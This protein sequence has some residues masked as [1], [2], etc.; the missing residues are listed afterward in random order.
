M[1]IQLL[2]L[3]HH[4]LTHHFLSA[5]RSSKSCLLLVCF[6]LHVASATSSISSNIQVS[7]KCLLE[8]S[9]LKMSHN[10]ANYLQLESWGCLV[11]PVEVFNC[12]WAE[13]SWVRVVKLFIYGCCCCTP[14]FSIWG[15]V[16][17]PCSSVGAGHSTSM[18]WQFCCVKM[19][20]K[21]MLVSVNTTDIPL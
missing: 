13:W 18:Y 15:L 3:G 10:I 19:A 16:C 20:C 7:S 8:M 14:I 12:V 17:T 9:Y 11:I 4:Y 5:C 21:C 2:H 6:K 1:V